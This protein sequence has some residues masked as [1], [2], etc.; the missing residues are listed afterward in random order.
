M[1]RILLALAIGLVGLAVGAGIVAT[2]GPREGRF[3]RQDRERQSDLRQVQT[4]LMC[5]GETAVLPDRLDDP[6]FCAHRTGR[7]FLR[8][9]ET[10]E[11]YGFTRVSD[12][13]FEVCAQTRSRRFGHRAVFGSSL[14]FDGDGKLCVRG[15]RK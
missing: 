15:T 11:L 9:P 8:D 2:G 14:R 6:E 1:T 13:T 7:D 12:Q 5:G 3:E 10:G 4:F